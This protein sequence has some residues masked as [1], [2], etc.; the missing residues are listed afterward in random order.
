MPEEKPAEIERLSAG[1]NV[2]C[3]EIRVLRT[4]DG[5][6]QQS[7]RFNFFPAGPDWETTVSSRLRDSSGIAPDSLPENVFI[8]Y[9]LPALLSSRKVRV[10]A[11][12]FHSGLDRISSK[13]STRGQVISCRMRGAVQRAALAITLRMFAS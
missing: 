6:P 2:S 1:K 9:H 8:I 12:R 7:V 10:S 5:I 11:I 4:R 3:K 13:A